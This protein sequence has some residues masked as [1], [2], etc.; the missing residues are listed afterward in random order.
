MSHTPVT[1]SL[2]PRSLW[3]GPH[4]HQPSQ[5]HRQ[6]FTCG[7]GRGPWMA[8]LSHCL[9]G[10]T[11]QWARSL[12]LASER[13]RLCSQQRLGNLEEA[14]GLFC[15]ALEVAY[16]PALCFINQTAAQPESCLERDAEGR[17]VDGRLSLLSTSPSRVASL[18]CRCGSLTVSHGKC[19]LTEL[20]FPLD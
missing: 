17:A 19:S 6:L 20:A 7:T 8:L 1:P 10:P 2:G 4:H 12:P 16:T 18:S 9:Q 15:P 14:T 5:G 11:A 13:Q 3:P